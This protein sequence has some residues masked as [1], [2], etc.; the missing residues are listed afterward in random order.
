MLANILD[1]CLGVTYVNNSI[2]ISSISP[3]PFGDAL[4]SFHWNQVVKPRT[5]DMDMIYYAFD[6]YKFDSYLNIL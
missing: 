3:L 6:L 5:T 1:W 2:F 4:G